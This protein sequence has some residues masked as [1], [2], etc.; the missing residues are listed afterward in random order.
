MKLE[1]KIMKLRKQ[2]AW[3]QEELAEKLNVTRQTVSKWELGQTVPDTEKLTN[4]SSIFGVSVNDLLDESFSPTEKISQN[5]NSKNKWKIIVLIVILIFVIL[6]IFAIT[7][8]ICFNKSSR[9]EEPKTVVE[10]F[11]Q[12]SFDDIFK[13]IFGKFQESED[14]FKKIKFNN[15]FKSLYYGTTNGSF[16]NDFFDEVLKSNEEHSDKIITV[17]F[18][19]IESNNAKDIKEIKKQIKNS[20]AKNYEIYYEYDEKGYINKAIIEEDE[21]KISEF[22]VKRFNQ[23]FKSNYFGSINGFFMNGFIDEVI[24][25][26]QEN[27]NNI[28]TVKFEK[29]ETNDDSKLREMKKKFTNRKEYEIIYKY[30][31]NGLINKAIVEETK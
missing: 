20:T 6:G 14:E 25:S 31:K 7:I 16:M 5:T 2:N 27:P 8:N 21:E 4:I 10:M 28:I 24:K 19:D 12:Y 15:V 13:T 3:S 11:K 23:I 18:K 1:E 26:N 29:V 22:E 17:K 30:D 9:Q